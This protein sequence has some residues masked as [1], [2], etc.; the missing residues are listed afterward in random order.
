MVADGMVLDFEELI[1]YDDFRQ[2]LDAVSVDL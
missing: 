1:F 2:Q